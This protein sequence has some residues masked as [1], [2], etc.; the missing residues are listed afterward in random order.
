MK[1]WT[2]IG[3]G[4][5]T[6]DIIETI[7]ALGD[8]P[9][10]LLLNMRI[11]DR[12]LASIPKSIEKVNIDKFKPQTDNY[13]F[14]FVDTGKD[15]LEKHLEKYHLNYANLIHPFS[16]IARSLKLGKGNYI[17]AGVVIAAGVS[18]IGNFNYINRNASLGHDLQMGNYNRI[19]PGS[20]ITGLCKIGNK[21]I[22]GAGSIM[23]DRTT[24]GDNI[25]LGAGAV[26]LSDIHTPGTYV[27]IPAKLL[28]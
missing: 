19:N 12:V 3:A 9:S 2:I 17:A 22:L 27:G 15:L 23:K 20:V 7:L 4:Y 24:I 5:I 14:G 16:A 28:T 21:N 1:T 6:A 25:I 13:I 26:V 18:T 10:Q 8:K 11:E